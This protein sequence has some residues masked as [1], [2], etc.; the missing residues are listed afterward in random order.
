MAPKRTKA[1]KGTSQNLYLTELRE[2]KATIPHWN[3]LFSDAA[4]KS[5]QDEWIRVHI[6]GRALVEVNA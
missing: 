4:R 2:L 3:D 1:S 6:I 5:M